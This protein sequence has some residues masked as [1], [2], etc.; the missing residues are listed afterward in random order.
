MA[1]DFAELVK[2]LEE[3]KAVVVEEVEVIESWEDAVPNEQK[4]RHIMRTITVDSIESIN[5]YIGTFLS[6]GWRLLSFHVVKP[7]AGKDETGNE[8]IV[9]VVGL[10]VLV[11]D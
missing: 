8:R 4:I 9:G 1:K 10:W 2:D 6:E 11:R 5:N 3:E 7:S